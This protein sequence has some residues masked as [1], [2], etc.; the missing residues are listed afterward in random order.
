MTRPRR[1]DAPDLER[2]IDLTEA[3]IERLKCRPGK[4]Q[5]F[6]RD[7]D[8][9]G[10]KV[11]I[12]AAAGATSF[13]FEKKLRRETI[14]FPIGDVTTWSIDE[15]RKKARSLAVKIDEGIDPR[16]VERQHEATKAAQTAAAA[17]LVITAAREAVTVG[18]VWAVYLAARKEHWGELHYKDHVKLSRAG[19]VKAKRGADGRGLTI[20][21]PLHSLMGVRLRDLDAP[22]IEA[23]ASQEAKTRPTSGRLAWRLLKVFLNWCAEQPEYTGL[24]PA[25]NAA[26]TRKAR[27]TLG[28]A[29]PK[30]DALLKEQLPAWFG[31]VRSIPNPVIAAALQVMLLTGARPGE[32][33]SMRWDDV[34]L[35]WRG[36]TMR[37]KVEGARV[38][39]LTPYASSLLAALPRRNAMVFSSATAEAGALTAPRK[40]HVAA[41]AVAGIDGLSLHGLRRSF[42]SLTE[43]LEIPAGVVAQI[44]GHK[45]S[46]T[47]EKHYTIRPLDLLRLHHEKIEAW[48]LEQAGVH[49]DAKAASAGTLR[50]VSG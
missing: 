12:T 18:E 21:M 29:R 23:W 41:C 5:D 1:D 33:L 7:S 28:K 47:V 42:K 44:M 27:E 19:G 34:N 36:V 9:K 4:S 45:P 10:L 30:T 14:R 43:W 13:V 46:A 25:K 20:A 37:D 22:T 3:L 38:I 50:V 15:A 2:P 26:A 40:H 31:A 49:F 35:K 11:R 39:P 6:A 8:T 24:M 48:I 17:A 32:V 16:E